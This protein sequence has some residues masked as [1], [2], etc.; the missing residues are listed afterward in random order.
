MV[1][2]RDTTARK[3]ILDILT[4]SDK[5]RTV[6]DII[7][8]LSEAALEVDRTTVFR[9]MNAFTD[10][11]IVRKLE[12]G[13][14]NFRYELLSLPHHYHIVCTHCG[15]IRDVEGCDVDEIEKQTAKKYNFKIIHHRLDFFGLCEH[16][17]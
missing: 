2:T 8:L 11:G 1:K 16:C 17:Q 13:E 5:P 7:Q 9:I 14:G 12:F 3:A 4:T 15:T 6:K 10:R